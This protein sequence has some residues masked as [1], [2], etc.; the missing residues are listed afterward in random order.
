MSMIEAVLEKMEEVACECAVATPP[1]EM[2]EAVRE[3]IAA[4]K[5]GRLDW[6]EGVSGGSFGGG[7][8]SPEWAK[9][10]ELLSGDD[11][12]KG[13]LASSWLLSL[14]VAVADKERLEGVYS[15]ADLLSSMQGSL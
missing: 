8:L 5:S 13:Q 2:L 15:S 11:D 1:E 12:L 3:T 9:L 7:P 6:E 4:A 10:A 14:L